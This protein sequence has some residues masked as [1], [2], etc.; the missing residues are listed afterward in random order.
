ML[1][2]ISLCIITLSLFLFGC[3]SEK[4]KYP[5]EYPSS[6]SYSEKDILYPQ[7]SKQQILLSSIAIVD[8]SHTDLG[9]IMA[10][11]SHENK[12]RVKIQ[13]TSSQ[14]EQTYNYDLVSLEPI[15]FPL[16]MGNG[17][18]MIKILENIQGKQYAIVKTLEIDVQIKDELSPFLYP[19]QLVNYQKG[20]SITHKAIEVV[21]KDDNDL[22]RIKD[23]YTFVADYLTYDDQKA[24]EANEKYILPDLNELLKIKKGICFDYAAL[25]VAMLRINHIPARLICGNTDVEYHAWVE[26]YLKGKGWVNPDIFMDE[27]TWTRMDPTFASSKF[28][29]DGQYDAIYYY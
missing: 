9:Y 17:K 3:Q 28:D 2:K 24:A 23:I 16:Q 6:K 5:S 13:I 8:Y 19:N 29:Y 22:Q 21:K 7:N 10:Y 14:N 27:K 12:K 26:V 20:D 15:A 1:K 25:M 11:L 4:K 18:Y